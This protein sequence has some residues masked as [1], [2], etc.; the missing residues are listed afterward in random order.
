MIYKRF[1]NKMIELKLL[2]R[3]VTTRW[4]TTMY[5][6]YYS[7]ILHGSLYF[8][9]GLQSDEDETLHSLQKYSCQSEINANVFLVKTITNE[10]KLHSSTIYEIE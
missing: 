1:E 3:I 10:G 2:L 5:H 7:T 8:S 4:Y 6:Y 9:N